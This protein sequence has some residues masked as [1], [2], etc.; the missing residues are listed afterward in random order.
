MSDPGKQC[1]GQA[2][3]QSCAKNTLMLTPSNLMALKSKKL[4]LFLFATTIIFSPAC[5]TENSTSTTSSSATS[6]P[7]GTTFTVTIETKTNEHPAF[8]EGSSL[9]F[10][11]DGVQGN[12]GEALVLARGNTYFFTVNSMSGHPF[13]LTTDDT[14][15]A[16]APGEI[17][18][19]V[20]DSQVESGTVEFTPNEN[21][22]DLIY[23]QCASHE[24]MGWEIELI[25]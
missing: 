9:G 22:A 17:T 24:S 13:Y 4:F 14:G 21:H 15:G 7:D 19:G 6:E 20:S 8:G 18:D 11:I 5:G 16:G 25:D 2:T 1:V 3:F 12:A 23:Y 10:A